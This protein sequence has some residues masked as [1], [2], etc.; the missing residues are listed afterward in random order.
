MHRSQV[1]HR[2]NDTSRLVRE[3]KRRLHARSRPM[4]AL[5]ATSLPLS[6]RLLLFLRLAVARF[7]INDSIARQTRRGGCFTQSVAII[8][9]LPARLS[10][11]NDR[12]RTLSRV[13]ASATYPQVRA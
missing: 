4:R 12:A 9:Y 11:S 10:R 3:I 8:E 6:P 2:R 13:R 1:R 7:H 5:P